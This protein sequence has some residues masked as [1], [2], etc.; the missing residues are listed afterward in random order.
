VPKLLIH[1]KEKFETEKLQV[2]KDGVDQDQV[3]K[4]AIKL[5]RSIDA[6]KV[7]VEVVSTNKDAEMS[8][9]FNQSGM[10]KKGAICEI[11][12]RDDG[13]GLS[14]TIDAKFE[15]TLRSGVAPLLKK[16]GKKLDL[17]LRGVTGN[18]GV[19]SGF[20]ARV[21]GG[22]LE[23]TAKNWKTTFPKIREFSIK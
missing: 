18:D 8:F 7:G 22:D 2:R 1:V 3:G 17:R 14:C 16:P 10:K 5:F 12:I 11:E 20:F 21:A 6:M 19:W 23:Q 4:K 15:V 9:V 13:N